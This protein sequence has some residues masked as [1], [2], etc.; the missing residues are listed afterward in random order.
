MIV[1]ELAATNAIQAPNTAVEVAPTAIPAGVVRLPMVIVSRIT[2]RHPPIIAP[3]RMN[4][5]KR[6]KG[7][8]WPCSGERRPGGIE[9][10][11]AVAMGGWS[12]A[13]PL[14]CRAASHARRSLAW[15]RSWVPI[16]V[17]PKCSKTAITAKSSP[18]GRPPSAREHRIK[19]ASNTAM[20][21]VHQNRCRRRNRRTGNWGSG[22]PIPGVSLTDAFNSAF[23]G[24]A[25][26]HRTLSES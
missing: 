14:R 23:N 12:S 19:A 16:A 20:P 18:N 17:P 11:A 1:Q 3:A 25:P 8:W 21:V 10:V 9:T 13:T 4:S 22:D 26:R 15:D 6:R 5:G 24:N 2:P 7:F